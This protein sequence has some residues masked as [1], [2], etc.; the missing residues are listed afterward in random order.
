MIP[1]A[2]FLYFGV[3][4][5]V[6]LPAIVVRVMGLG[7]RGWILIATGA[8]LVVQYWDTQALWPEQVVHGF[9]I[10]AGYAAFEWLVAS[11]FLRA[12]AMTAGAGPE[13]RASGTPPALGGSASIHRRALAAIA[14][15][16]TIAPLAMVKILPTLTIDQP[17]G[18]LG[19]SYVTFRCIDVV[20][21][22]E[23]RLIASLSPSQ[24]LA[25][26]LFFPTISAGPIDRF[27]RFDRDWKREDARAGLTSDLNEAVHRI[28]TGFFYKFI[29]AALV[30]RQWMDPAAAHVGLSH[31][32]SYMYA[33][34]VYLFF[35]FAGYSAFAV[36]VS[37]LFG[38]HA[39]D[40]FNR[41]FLAE[42]IRDF[43]NRWHISLSWWFRDHVYMRLMMAATKGRW[44]ANRHMASALALVVAFGLMGLWHGTQAHFIFYGLYHATLLV[45][46]ETFVRWN[47]RHQ[48]WGEGPLWRL[49]GIALTF[50]AVCFGFLIF[51]GRLGL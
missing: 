23:D 7:I 46:Y 1:Y 36:G 15:A 26:V 47:K 51:S 19:I 29:V 6:A 24:Y 42:N 45:G 30:K 11:A 22:I 37:Y 50:N 35:D 5:Y 18:F 14:L 28:F 10:V 48:L 49:S 4:L 12:K 13:S 32:L 39:P 44:F 34:S 27:R 8:M 40:N 33:Y 38:I 16:L 9:W 3:L 41:P 2:G 20:L 21:L 17:V 43:W 25:Y 31:T